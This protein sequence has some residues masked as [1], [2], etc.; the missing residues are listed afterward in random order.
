MTSTTPQ[1]WTQLTTFSR[2]KSKGQCP[3]LF[4]NFRSSSNDGITLH[5]TDLISLWRSSLSRLEIIATAGEQH[6]SIDPSEST[7]QMRV[8]LEKLAGSLH[9]G[10]NRLAKQTNDEP[11]SK[12]LALETSIAL[13][14]PLKP[15]DWTFILSL[16]PASELAEQIL[17]PTLHQLSVS[18]RKLESMFDV[19]KDKDHVIERLLDRVAEKGVDMSL[20]FPTLTGT[21]KKSAGGV[22]VE[23]ARRLVPGMKVFANN[24]WEQQFGAE[25]GN[26][27]EVGLTELVQGCEKCFVHSKEEHE[28]WIEKLPRLESSENGSTKLSLSRSQ[29]QSQSQS[30]VK[31]GDDTDSDNEF[32]TQATP[33]ALRKKRESPAAEEAGSPAIEEE[34]PPA[35]R[36]KIG[37]VGQLGRRKQDTKVSTRKEQSS[38]P[39]PAVQTSSPSERRKS[40]ASTGTETASS[41]SDSNH[42]PLSTTKAGPKA[43]RPGGLPKTSSTQPLKIG[44][45]QRS[46]SP[47][48]RPATAS[49]NASTQ[50]H[51]LGRI[52][53]S[54]QRT[55]TASPVPENGPAGEKQSQPDT[56]STRMRNK[57]EASQLAGER[58]RTDGRELS[59]K[60]GATAE[61]EPDAP[62]SASD[63][64]SASPSPLP[65]PAQGSKSTLKGGKKRTPA[66]T[67]GEKDNRADQNKNKEVQRPETEDQKANR[68]R[69]ELK[70]AIQ[71]GGG[72]KKKRRF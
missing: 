61:D 68:R 67:K 39:P 18:D 48:S 70:R 19:V 17:R 34:H 30:Q 55:A 44:L 72:A 2:S 59:A 26:E 15:L 28:A 62:A 60:K 4:Y 5:L 56:P 13:P 20:I 65:S 52:G 51:R 35:K 71:T 10:T 45:P 43:A 31:A 22:R 6:T 23:E 41:H 66:P 16:Q 3:K 57:E 8:F 12:E 27:M 21:A 53:K 50:S 38:S 42:H 37:K 14:R 54:R 25:R 29:S 9:R 63:S 49:S 47:P 46:P 58:E 64:A 24:T 69:E 11:G 32:E 36:A 33:P 1:G 40:D 7:E